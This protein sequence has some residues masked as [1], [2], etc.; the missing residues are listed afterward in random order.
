[1][2]IDRILRLRKS[3]GRLG[4][5]HLSQLRKLVLQTDLLLVL[6]DLIRHAESR[7]LHVPLQRH[8][9]LYLFEHESLELIKEEV[10]LV[11][12]NNVDDLPQRLTLCRIQCR[13]INEHPLE[14]IPVAPGYLLYEPRDLVAL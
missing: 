1:M 11:L 8:A 3:F 2:H 6:Y 13:R 4:V 14:H 5:Q 12:V 7:I 9:L 10:T